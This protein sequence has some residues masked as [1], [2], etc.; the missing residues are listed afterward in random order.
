MGRLRFLLLPT[1]A[2]FLA[3]C[4]A[5]LPLRPAAD[6]VATAEDNGAPAEENIATPADQA[7]RPATAEVTAEDTAKESAALAIPNPPL[8]KPKPDAAS[9]TARKSASTPKVG[10]ADWKRERAEDARKEEHLKEVIESIC[11][12]C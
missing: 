12:G 5:S 10:S 2:V 4:V 9:V 8:P 1:F 11:R 7:D 3:G 6:N